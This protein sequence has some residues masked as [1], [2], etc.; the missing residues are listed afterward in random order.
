MAKACNHRISQPRFCL[1]FPQ[2]VG[3]GATVLEAE[4]V[5]GL[6]LTI[7]GGKRSGISDEGNSLA[8]VDAV[9]VAALTADGGVENLL[10]WVH[11]LGAFRTFAP[12][13]EK[14]S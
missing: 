13:P 8:A 11:H 9:V 7:D 4:G 10:F 12:E 3:I 14:M 1:G 5:G 6:K 2:T